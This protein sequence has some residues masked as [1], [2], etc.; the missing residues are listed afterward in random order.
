MGESERII[1]NAWR[2]Q[3]QEKHSTLEANQ[4]AACRRC[5]GVL[6][7]QE[8]QYAGK[9]SGEGQPLAGLL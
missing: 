6:V 1:R 4:R 8:N 7:L 2:K 3:R 9:E 5:K